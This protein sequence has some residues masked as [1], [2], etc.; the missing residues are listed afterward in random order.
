M[1]TK[2]LVLLAIGLYGL[3]A[4][5][6]KNTHPYSSPRTETFERKQQRKR[7]GMTLLALASLILGI[8]GLSQYLISKN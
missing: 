5:F 3:G 7:I 6:M 2:L 8:A 1:D 4:L